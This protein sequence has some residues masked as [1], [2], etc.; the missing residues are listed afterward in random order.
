MEVSAMKLSEL[1]DLRKIGVAR[2]R[3]DA[4]G[5]VLEAIFRLPES[6]VARETSEPAETIASARAQAEQLLYAAS[7]GFPASYYASVAKQ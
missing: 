2:V 3:L 5:N 7:E 4:D 6:E 1:T